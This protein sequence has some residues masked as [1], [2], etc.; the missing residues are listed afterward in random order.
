MTRNG[1]KV[2]TILATDISVEDNFNS[3]FNLEFKVNKYNNNK[4][5]H[6]WDELSDF[7]LVWCR[8][9]NV[10]FEVNF[11]TNE[12]DDTV[13]SATGISLGEAETSQINL[14][15]IQI[16]TEDDI[17]RD[18]Y[19]PTV[20]YNDKNHKASLLHRIMEKAPHYSIK[21]VDPSISNIQR[22]FSFDNKSLY[23]SFQEIAKEINCIFVFDNG[24]DENGKIKRMVSVYD[25]ENYC[26][27]CGYRDESI[28]KCPKCGNTDIIKGYGEDTNIFITTE[29]LSDQITFKT[30]T[31]SVK[32]CFRLEAG[33]DLMT[34]TVISCNPNGSQYIY[35][36]SDEMKKDMSKELTSKLS[37]Y[38]KLYNYY[39]NEYTLPVESN[40]LSSYNALVN[41][42]SVYK[43]DLQVIPDSI[44]GY[45]SLMNLYYDTIDFYLFLNDTLMPSPEISKTS[46]SKEATKITP[47]SLAPVAVS[48]LSKCSLTTASSAVSAMA[49][50]IVDHRYQVRTSDESMTE[51]TWSGK[52]IITNYSDD[53]D[54][55]T[56][57]IITIEISD[58][59]EKFV[60]QKID[61]ILSKK[62]DDES[63]DIVTLFKLKIDSFKNDLKK[64]CLVSL[65]TF[66]DSCQA[67][68]D[69][70][71][72]QGVADGK[73]WGD[74]NPNLYNEIYLDYYNKMSAIQEEIKVRESE[75]STI[76]GTLN[77]DGTRK[78]T[79]IQNILDKEKNEI[80]KKLNLEH[81]L[82]TD[83]WL[84]FSSYRRE[85]SYQNSNYISDGLNNKD[86]FGK[87]NEF[88][89]VAKKEI[90]KSATLQH[91]ISASLYNLLAIKEFESITDYFSVGN[92]M[93]IRIDDNVYKLRLISYTIDFNDLKEV[94]VKFSD[95]KICADG[96]SDTENILSQASSMATTYDAVTRQASQGET[97]NKQLQDW[98]MN[99]LSLT[100]MKIVDNAD[101]QNITWDSHGLLCRE[102]DSISDNYNDKQLKIINKGLYLTDDNWLTSK[103]GIGEFSYYNPKANKIENS[104][105]VIADTLVGNLILSEEVGVY[106]TD[107]SVVMDKNGLTITADNT[108]TSQNQT[109][110]T[111][112]KRTLDKEN[113]EVL[114]KM[115]YLD[116][117]CNLVINGS[118]RINSQSGIDTLTSWVDNNITTATTEVSNNLSGTIKEN[119][120]ALADSIERQS[121]EINT[122]MSDRVNSLRN[123]LKEDS[124]EKYNFLWNNIVENQDNL[125]TTIDEQYKIITKE[126][127]D[128]LNAYKAEV[129][130]FL[131]FN[132]SGLTIG[133]SSSNFKTSIDNQGM[134]FMQGDVRVAY[135]SNNQLYIPNAIIENTLSLGKFFFSPHSNGDGG[136]SLTWQG[137]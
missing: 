77:N 28:D 54:T 89:S 45:S 68:L 7:K 73:T 135:I 18:D 124:E 35:Y 55:A 133:A 48:D 109:I 10:V 13:K 116:S 115:M 64:Y 113:K 110:L 21:H 26:P 136:V 69:L 3:S 137:D 52:F 84:E 53:E 91:S 70:L 134:Y 37:D 105:G 108:S 27:K 129:G 1:N 58:N 130:Q 63:T 127:D 80:Q 71:V 38:D 65:K 78:I 126:N 49:R 87:A 43:K 8:E 125:Y 75:I 22:T 67:C 62:Q 121:N 88:L 41:K 36:I 2:G 61:K 32:N 114:T 119:Y 117:D 30:D 85:D 72:E 25:L 82:G 92:W 90:Y 9:W 120:D 29:N 40:V 94:S 24:L 60:K 42:Y 103:A 99:G 102:F 20:L 100:K 106:N 56:T 76:A 104:Y 96:I 132:S 11:T 47:A 57:D 111:V 93:R 12:T 122:T 31:D 131:E 97:S 19:L 16:N 95:V 98:T 123:E 23:D 79:G 6:L 33:D 128:K 46:A 34:A 14:Y 44:K 66:L 107:N 112:Q 81:Y 101:N 59:Y 17:K 74:K 118:V 5:Y 15:N 83:L 4:K 86:L 39:Y 51:Y 50:T